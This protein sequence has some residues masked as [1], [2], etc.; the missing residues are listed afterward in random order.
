MRRGSHKTSMK[1]LAYARRVFN[2]QGVNKKQIALDC[3]YS[4]N[5]ANSLSSHIENKPGFL[6][7]MATLAAESN[8]LA[9]EALM[10]FKLRGF[11]E[12]SNQEMIGALNA[13][14]SAWS[15]FNPQARQG[16]GSN[17]TNRLR[18]I[19]LQQIENQT[20]SPVIRDIP[21]VET[22]DFWEEDNYDEAP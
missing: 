6:N 14:G 20:V 15:K 7:A 2:G 12:F 13:I 1:Q 9:L 10:E 16:E 3:G 19:I 22:T 18:T 17:S 21:A 11:K 8:N 4:H 5:V